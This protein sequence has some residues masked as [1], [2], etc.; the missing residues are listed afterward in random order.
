MHVVVTLLRGWTIAWS[1]VVAGSV[2]EGGRAVHH[3]FVQGGL[4]FVARFGF[5]ACDGRMVFERCQSA[6]MAV[7]HFDNTRASVHHT[8]GTGGRIAELG[9]RSRRSTGAADSSI[10]A[11]IIN[12]K[13]GCDSREGVVSSF[14]C[15][16]VASAFLVASFEMVLE[17]VPR[18]GNGRKDAPGFDV[19]L[20]NLV[21]FKRDK[22]KV[23]DCFVTL[24]KGSAFSKFLACCCQCP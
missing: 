8:G 18:L 1:C 5:V 20:E 4:S 3:I 22:E 6:G 7:I 9:G 10:C 13:V 17:I 16:E 23:H 15:A 21:F 14:P 19:V 11:I 12:C 2:H 24:G